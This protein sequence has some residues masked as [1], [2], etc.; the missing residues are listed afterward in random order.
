MQSGWKTRL[1]FLVSLGPKTGWRNPTFR[2]I[3]TPLRTSF[4]SLQGGNIGT[5][6]WQRTVAHEIDEGNAR[7]RSF[8]LN[9]LPPVME[10]HLIR[11]LSLHNAS[12]D[13]RNPLI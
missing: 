12:G 8:R 5:T 11:P 1:S 4:A 3:G 7:A 9:T 10:V 13:E 6:R 2:L